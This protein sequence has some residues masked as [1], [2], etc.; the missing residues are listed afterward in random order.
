MR[1]GGRVPLVVATAAVAGC[2][3]LAGIEDLQLTGSGDGGSGSDAPVN[4]DVS[5]A[6][7]TSG[8]GSGGEGGS[9]SGGGDGAA[10]SSSGGTDGSSSGSH[11]GSGSNSSSSSGGDSSGGS[12]GGQDAGT[13]C[14]GTFVLCD[15]F[16]NGL[17]TAVWTMESTNDAN[18]SI[19]VVTDPTHAHSGTHSLHV[20]VAALTTSVYVQ[21]ELH[22]TKGF[23]SSGA[24]YFRAWYL[25]SSY[26]GVGAQMTTPFGTSGVGGF[27]F[28]SNGFLNAGVVNTGTPNDY[29]YPSTTSL[30]TNTWTCI[31]L[32]TNPSAGSLGQQQVYVDSTT[33]V[34]AL[35]GTADMGTLTMLYLGLE[36]GGPSSSPVDL[37]IDDLAV[38]STYVGCSQ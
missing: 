30:P 23:P 3:S 2:A 10:S 5:V 36:Y 28:D 8:S 21:P 1:W 9:G 20:H 13:D 27:G 37:W 33:P 25:L 4:G 14:P 24:R 6:D 12:S 29:N 26:P 22:T 32:M 7:S 18:Q 31:E 34:T 38:D 17:D 16:E 15:G 35:S 19:S 11:D